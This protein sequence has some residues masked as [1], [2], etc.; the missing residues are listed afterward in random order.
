[1]NFSE[2]F[3]LIENC[4]AKVL[5]EH[6]LFGKQVHHCERLR[7]INDDSRIGLILKQQEIFVYKHGLTLCKMCKNMLVVA[8]KILQITIIVNNM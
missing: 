4:K 5:L 3:N 6:S 8:D 1:M 2:N 7:I